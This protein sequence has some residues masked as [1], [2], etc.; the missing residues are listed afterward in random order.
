MKN[1]EFRAREH[2]PIWGSDGEAPEADDVF[3]TKTL[4]FDALV[5]VFSQI[6]ILAIHMLPSNVAQGAAPSR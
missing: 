4:I 2:E 5:I 1:L 6:T 3:V